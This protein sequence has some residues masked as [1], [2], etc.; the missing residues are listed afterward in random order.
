[1]NEAQ[2]IHDAVEGNTHGKNKWAIL[3]TVL[4][5]T[6]MATLDSSIVNVALPVMQKE[7][8][9]GLD[10]IQWVSSVYLLTTCA[11][12]LVFGRLGDIHGKVRFFQFGVAVFAFGSLL[13]GMAT[14]LWFLVVAR[15]V[16]GIGAAS[17]MANNM[18]IITE[19][20]PARER[21]RALGLLAS[22]VALGM[23]CGPVLGG[24]IVSSLPWELIFLIN[25]PVGVL[26]LAVGHWTLPHVKPDLGGRRL[27]VAGSILL[28]PGMFLTFVSI[29]LIEA[30]A[31]PRVIS[32][33]AAGSALLIAFVLVERRVDDPLVV[34][35]VFC[36]RAFLVN[37]ACLFISFVAIGVYELMTPFYLQDAR[38]FA[39]DV[40]GLIFCVIPLANAI[41]GPISGAVSDRIGCERPTAVGLLV[42][43]IGLLLVGFFDEETSLIAILLCLGLASL[44]TSI[45]QSPNNSLV[46]GSLPREAL[47]FGGSL[48]ALARYLG[49]AVGITGST[50][51]LY[52]RMSAMAGERVTTYVAGRPDIFLYGYKA[53]YVATAALVSIGFALTL[54]RAIG[55]RRR[56]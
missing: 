5:M 49:M 9:A 43:A 42:F 28:V 34:L 39:P 22:F 47:G 10:Q 41:A 54:V 19:S 3:F 53:V 30:G 18:G 32:M 12:L 31:T 11:V 33:L 45:F 56:S 21:G 55:R 24:F 6:F 8:G 29:T 35:S 48:A 51:L 7:L 13:C 36:D 25:V 16:Q 27:D 20:F 1:M 2:L 14:T 46:M 37:L 38:G 40:A 23:M 17:A 26:S 50:S 15:A 44:G 52:G 4:V